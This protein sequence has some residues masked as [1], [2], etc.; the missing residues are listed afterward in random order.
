ML[1]EDLP[2]CYDRLKRIRFLPKMQIRKIKRRY[3]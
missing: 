3:L 1:V 2:D